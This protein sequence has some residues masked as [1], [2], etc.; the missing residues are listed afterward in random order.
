MSMLAGAYAE[1]VL[2]LAAEQGSAKQVYEA[3][4]AARQALQQT[5]AYHKLLANPV[6]HSKEKKNLLG[7]WLAQ[8]QKIFQNMAFLLC[9][10]GEGGLLADVLDCYIQKYRDANGIVMVTAVSAVPIPE[11]LAAQL[12]QAL[13]K[14]TGKTVLVENEVDPACIGGLRLEMNGKQYDGSV[15]AR[16]DAIYKAMRGARRQGRQE[17][18]VVGEVE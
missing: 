12:E 18:T 16:L 11:H 15:Q 10:K 3:C 5:P 2:Q 17:N 4:L 9:D 8:S 6:V 13:V 14:S 7:Q 1:A